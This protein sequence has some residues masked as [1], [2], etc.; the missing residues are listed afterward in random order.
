MACRTCQGDR[1]I[2]KHENSPDIPCPD[3]NVTKTMQVALSTSVRSLQDLPK[4]KILANYKPV[5]KPWD[6]T[7]VRDQIF[8]QASETLVKWLDASLRD[9]QREG[10]NQD[11]IQ[12]THRGGRSLIRVN[13]V[14]R[15]EFKMKFS[16]GS[17]K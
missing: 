5:H 3:C 17:C 11:D 15:Y 16:Y 12:I 7:P 8:Q 2:N 9:L 1:F 6:I 10:V 13:G 14:D 4:E